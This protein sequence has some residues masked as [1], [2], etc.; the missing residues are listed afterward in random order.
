M[1]SSMLCGEGG[2]SGQSLWS[3]AEGHKEQ[4]VHVTVGQGEGDAGK[5][6]DADLGGQPGVP[7]TGYILG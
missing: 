1:L 3:K 4:E 6:S 2:V 5:E 7:Y